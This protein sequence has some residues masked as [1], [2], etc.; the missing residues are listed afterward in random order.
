V[1]QTSLNFYVLI[2]SL[3]LLTGIGCAGGSDGVPTTPSAENSAK[4]SSVTESHGLWGY[5]QVTIDTQTGAV[6]TVPVREAMFHL[7]VVMYLQPPSPMGM[8]IN[9]NDMN[10]ETGDFDID[11]SLTHPFP[12]PGLKGFDVKGILITNG[13]FYS[14]VDNSLRFSDYILN[15]RMQNADG[16][17]RWWN[18]KEFT[19]SGMFG[20]TEGIVG[21][22]WTTITN[23]LNPFKYFADH[24]DAEDE[25]YVPPGGRNHFSESATN[26]RKYLINFPIIFG[27]PIIVFN[28]AVDA[29]WQA[30]DG[31]PTDV[32]NFPPEANQPEAYQITVAD[33]GTTAWFHEGSGLYGGDVRLQIGVRDYGLATSSAVSEE[34]EALILE[35]RTL[36]PTPIVLTESDVDHRDGDG[37]IFN[38]NI[39]N[40]T[41]DSADHQDILFHA[42]TPDLTYDQGLGGNAPDKPLAAHMI[43]NV[44]VI[45]GLYTP[46]APVI[47]DV[48]I[49]R[50]VNGKLQGFS[51]DWDDD[52]VSVEW[53][54]YWSEDPY[55][56]D[57]SLTFGLAD[58]GIVTEPTWSFD[59]TTS[60]SNDQWML[61]VRG[62]AIA[63]NPG[64][65]S[66]PSVNILIDFA[67]FDDIVE[68]EANKWR[69]R[70]YVD[71]GFNH[72]DITSTDTAGINGT[73]ALCI[74]PKFRFTWKATSYC[75]TPELPEISGATSCYLEMY[76]KRPV[77]YPQIPS[78][79]YDDD[80]PYGYSICST[81]EIL[82]PENFKETIP[83]MQLYDYNVDIVDETD[84][85]SGDVMNFSYID[86][87]DYRYNDRTTEL[88]DPSNGW[89]G[90]Q[91]DFA[92]TKYAIPKVISEGHSFAGVCWGG[93]QFGSSTDV[94]TNPFEYPLIV[95]E[96]AFVIY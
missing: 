48:H 28:Y 91:A 45:D 68:E 89:S 7:N 47:T 60:Q 80:W 42:V 37:A 41:P 50:D 30:S 57:G 24:L 26:T 5:W 87:L 2:F 78:A 93:K 16:H 85:I 82:N 32:N 74:I 8:G 43:Y 92:V 33:M 35:S 67:A 10:L 11:V 20:Y 73:G 52:D 66:D 54:V 38:V 95:D 69:L 79:P 83:Y 14:Q 53:V 59:I 44:D 36:F 84:W 25:F 21:T 46:P 18:Q 40:V 19:S 58:N 77:D 71:L 56:V 64:T 15:P 55:E 81:P 86:G 4:N 23:T 62:R 1:K 70:Y 34:L 88:T 90:A 12:D 3:I 22:R 76:H 9:I 63:D 6:E 65:E 61:C 75:V 51:I 27:D 39:E 13:A 94:T 72:F 29:C 49:D 31:D 17:T 96:I